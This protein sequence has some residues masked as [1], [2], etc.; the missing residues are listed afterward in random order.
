MPGSC[1]WS[2]DS[3]GASD[4]SE[5]AAE[6]EEQMK[7]REQIEEELGAED[8]ER[9]LIIFKQNAR[10]LGVNVSAAELDALQLCKQTWSL[11]AETAD[12]T[13]VLGVVPRNARKA[14]WQKCG[15]QGLRSD[16]ACCCFE[17]TTVL[18]LTDELELLF[19]GMES[20]C[21]T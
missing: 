2:D 14:F 6:Y 21:V 9:F 12:Q 15:E 4:E 10:R 19:R 11:L 1:Q 16:V 17:N 8:Q 7:Y 18:S 3:R 20:L 5:N 13:A